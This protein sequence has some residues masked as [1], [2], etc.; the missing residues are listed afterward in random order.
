MP[1]LPPEDPEHSAGAEKGPGPRAWENLKMLFGMALD[2]WAKYH[3]GA[4]TD[5]EARASDNRHLLKLLS[6]SAFKSVIQA[7]VK[8]GAGFLV[9]AL[10]AFFCSPKAQLAP[11]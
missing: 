2:L 4:V 10:Y 8:W 6:Y 7:L 5:L 3:A 9:E 1:G 11:G